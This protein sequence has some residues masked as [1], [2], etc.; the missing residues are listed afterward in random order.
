MIQLWTQ[1]VKK[2]KQKKGFRFKLI[3]TSE[4]QVW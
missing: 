1:L 3:R 2:L 4:Y